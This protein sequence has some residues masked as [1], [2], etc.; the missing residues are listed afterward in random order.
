MRLRIAADIGLDGE[1]AGDLGRD[2][3]KALGVEVDQRDPGAFGGEQ[4][5]RG[6]A[7]PRTRAGDD[8]DLVLEFHGEKSSPR[9]AHPHAEVTGIDETRRQSLIMC[10]TEE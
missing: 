4:P 5:G 10:R 6:G 3:V 1:R 9:V 2:F 8:G 7:D